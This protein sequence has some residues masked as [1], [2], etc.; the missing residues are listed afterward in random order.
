[1]K[2]TKIVSLIGMIF[3]ISSGVANWG[4]EITKNPIVVFIGMFV[5]IALYAVAELFE[6]E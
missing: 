1:M 6:G 5:F 3:A 4:S 2:L